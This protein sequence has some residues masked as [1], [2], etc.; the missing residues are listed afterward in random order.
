MVRLRGVRS[1]PARAAEVGLALAI[2]GAARHFRG[3][4]RTL[5]PAALVERGLGVVRLH[6]VAGRVDARGGRFTIESPAGGGTQLL[7]ELPCGS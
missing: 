3:I 5:M 6:G 7:V 4:V 1:A 2:D